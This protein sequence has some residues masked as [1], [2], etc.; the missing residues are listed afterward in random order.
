MSTFGL[1]L[2]YLKQLK[3]SLTEVIILQQHLF[4]FHAVD[5]LLK[6]KVDPDRPAAMRIEMVIEV[7]VNPTATKMSGAGSG[8]VGKKVWP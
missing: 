1:K 8:T 7:M 4:H 2:S 3:E 6:A 5:I